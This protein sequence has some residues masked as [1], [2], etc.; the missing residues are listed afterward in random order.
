MATPKLITTIAAC[1][2]LALG[3]SNVVGQGTTDNPSVS[4]P[5][6]QADEKAP[7]DGGAAHLPSNQGA[8]TAQTAPTE[9]C[10]TNM[11]LKDA[12]YCFDANR[13]GYNDL[14]V[15][16]CSKSR[17]KTATGFF[18]CQSHNEDARKNYSSC[19]PDQQLDLIRSAG[20]NRHAYANLFSCGF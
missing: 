5:Y 6:P 3:T 4:A 10:D 17:D 2:L 18:A 12:E 19:T 20:R 1:G 14:F 7:R 8:N 9:N 13:P 16:S 15:G 11:L